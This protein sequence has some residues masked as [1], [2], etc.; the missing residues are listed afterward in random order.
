[1][2]LLRTECDEKDL[3]KP[4]FK[5]EEALSLL[6]KYL[7]RRRGA[8]F[9]ATNIKIAQ[10][11]LDPLGTVVGGIARFHRCQAGNLLRAHLTPLNPLVPIKI[12][13][14]VFIWFEL[15]TNSNGLGKFCQI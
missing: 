2:E 11:H 14:I 12:V 15:D 5:F 1:M 9:D 3:A 7:L 4:A 13:V 10:I 8:L 6:F